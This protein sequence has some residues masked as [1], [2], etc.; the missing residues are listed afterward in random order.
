V[1]GWVPERFP[2]DQPFTVLG[3]LRAMAALRR[4][5]ATAADNW[6][7][8]LGLTE[9]VVTPLGALS[10]GTAQ[11]VGLAQA[12]LT[13]PGL[14]VLDEPWE[15]LDAQARTLIPR[16]V[17]EVN[18][19]GGAVLVSDHRGEIS[20]LPG[21]VHWSVSAG[22]L[23]VEP[24]ADPTTPTAHAGP[25]HA[26]PLS[27]TLL[28][29]GGPSSGEG[30]PSRDFSTQDVLPTAAQARL[31]AAADEVVIEIAVTGTEAEEAVAKLRAAGHRVLRI[32]AE[33]PLGVRGEEVR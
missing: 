32:R 29:G 9:H 15:G 22:R 19:A 18:A 26:G 16:I 5:P 3:Y 30:R 25:H 20:G 27:G 21:A 13:P 1:V 8:R 11:K 23:H 31:A 10:K 24:S 17:A 4:V 33:H 7:E 2:A 14:L 6:I 28:H 12:L